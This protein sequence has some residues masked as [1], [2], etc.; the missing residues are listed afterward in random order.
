MKNK[1]IFTLV[2]IIVL[3][4]FASCISLARADYQTYNSPIYVDLNGHCEF[5]QEE[6]GITYEITGTPGSV[7]TVIVNVE[8]GNPYTSAYYPEGIGLS[9]FVTISFDM[10]SEEFSSATISFSY[11]D[12]DVESIASPYAI[13]KYLPNSDAYV[14]IP[15]T[16]DEQA[17]TL[18][19]T[20]TSTD[21]PTFA[22]GGAAI[23]NDS[24]D[25]T[26]WIIIGAVSVIIVVVVTLLF[27]RMRSVPETKI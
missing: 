11:S 16:V 8:N 14:E 18:T 9:S 23:V 15:T 21:D 19:I 2:T 24:A 13:Y 12:S 25:N 4:A 10:D 20:L 26:M 27:M 1:S 5:Y 17:K 7:G 22:I 6:T 3:F